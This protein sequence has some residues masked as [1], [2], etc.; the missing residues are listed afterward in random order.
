L[1]KGEDEKRGTEEDGEGKEEKEIRIERIKIKAK[2]EKS[3]RT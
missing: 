2:E 1:K 3:A